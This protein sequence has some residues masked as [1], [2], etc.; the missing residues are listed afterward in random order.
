MNLRSR[1]FRALSAFYVYERI[2]E[3]GAPNIVGKKEASENIKVMN[4]FKNFFTIARESIRIYFLLELAKLFDDAQQSLHINKIISFSESN[5]KKL[6]RSEFLRFHQGQKREFLQELFKSYQELS[7][8]DLKI[9]RSDL[10]KYEKIIKKIDN[11]RD[12]YLAHDDKQ[13]TKININRIEI[14]KLFKVLKKILTLFTL[15]L[16]FSITY[17][18]HVEKDCKRDTERVIKYLRRFEKYRLSEI[19]AKY[20]I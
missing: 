12:Q 13:K 7:S 1:Y 18:D 8:K 3:L 20:K 16:D 4:H 17:Y 15:R 11:Y 10:K 6:S 5:I 9:V 19:E 14:I 2:R